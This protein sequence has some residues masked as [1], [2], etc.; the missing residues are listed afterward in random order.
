MEKHSVAWGSGLLAVAVG[1][2]AFGAHGL[3]ALIDP[4]AL[5]N[6]NTAV[7]YQF[8]HALGILVL[9]ALTGPLPAAATRR[10]RNLFLLGI[11]FFCGSLYLL[12]T[13]KLTGLDGMTAFIGPITPLGGVM[14]IVGWIG[15]LITVIR[16]KG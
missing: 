14:F 1:L 7:H 13:R 9:A 5:A 4:A 8:I 16:S 10:V 6:W 2:G 12:S 15:L 3:K 11:A